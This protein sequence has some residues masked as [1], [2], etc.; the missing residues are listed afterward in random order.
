M[1][2]NKDKFRQ[3]QQSQNPNYFYYTGELRLVA[4]PRPIE[5]GQ[6]C[7]VVAKLKEPAD[8][9]EV[10]TSATDQYQIDPV[11]D[12]LWAGQI[13]VPTSTAKTLPIA[14]VIQSGEGTFYKAYT[15]DVSA[16]NPYL[17]EEQLA[18]NAFGVTPNG[19]S[20]T[21]SMNFQSVG[22]RLT[23]N[24]L[25]N[26]PFGPVTGN[27]TVKGIKTISV[28]AKFK[29][30]TKD[31]FTE[32]MTRDENL[33]ITVAGK[34]ANTDVKA[35]FQDSSVKLDDSNH[36]S[37]ELKNEHGELIF[38]EY[39]MGLAGGEFSSFSKRLNGVK[40]VGHLGEFNVYAMISEAKGSATH[41]K[42]YGQNS[43]GPYS[44]TQRPIIVNSERI[45]YKGK[46]LKRDVDYSIDYELGQI[47]FKTDFV[48]ATDLFTV[49]YEYSDAL[50]RKNF[51]A[52][53]AEYAPTTNTN[54][55]GVT[56]LGL[57]ESGDSPT[58]GIQPRSHSQVGID[59]RWELQ[60]GLSIT[61]EAAISDHAGTKGVAFKQGVLAKSDQ[62]E[63]SG[64]VKKIGESFEPVGNPSLY[65][66][67]FG[68][69]F[70]GEWTPTASF[71]VK[72]SQELNR[73]PKNGTAVQNQVWS[74]AEQ[75][76]PVSHSFLHRSDRDLSTSGN[77]FDKRL[78]RNKVGLRTE[79]GVISLEPAYQIERSTDAENPTVNATN[80]S[81]FLHANL[82]GVDRIQLAS[83]IEWQRQQLD[84]Q[85]Q[86]SRNSYALSAAVEPLANYS[87]NGTAKLVDDQ[88]DGTSALSTLGYTLKPTRQIRLNGNYD[89]ETLLMQ[90]DVAKYRVMKHQAN[91]GFG[92]QP[93][94]GVEL[95]YRYKPSFSEVKPLQNLRY[96]DRLVR[97]YGIDLDY[98]ANWTLQSELKS[99]SRKTLNTHQF[100]ASVAQ[101]SGIEDALIVQNTYRL[102]E[103]TS[104][105][106]TFESEIKSA[107]D[108]QT[109]VTPNVT[110]QTNQTSQ[111]QEAK[112]SSQLTPDIKTGL[113][114]RLEDLIFTST[115]SPSA[116][117][118]QVTQSLDTEAEWQMNP[119]LTTKLSTATSKT[120]DHL[121]RNPDT[122]FA[123]PR[124]DFRYRPTH[125]W[126][127]TGF[128][129]ITQSW[130]GQPIRR[131]R[132]SFAAKYDT[133]IQ[134]VLNTTISGQ[135]DYEN[136]TAPTQ[137]DT[138][139]ALMKMSLIF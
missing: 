42:I 112:L 98:F 40:G 48:S 83:D 21:V 23:D 59:S 37:V 46:L 56:Y 4:I 14:V 25:L 30:G 105:S 133:L 104:L 27:L 55:I 122:Y 34:A 75:Y 127:F 18:L 100:P 118:N 137:Y 10:W 135:I 136:E 79:F 68:T 111:K 17:M 86:N 44:L 134:D 72:G 78:T 69:E 126:T 73:Y 32:G 6:P 29:S 138:W 26:T 9:I 106:H 60:P 108:L 87:F 66:G 94:S 125:E 24:N 124:L 123:V 3:I 16:K 70:R 7:Y 58:P 12:T 139:D 99:T 11:S 85:G 62:A 63:F 101:S 8:R 107:N 110:D 116:N 119:Q 81:I 67:L 121:G 115:F 114:I 120:V 35:T 96:D 74:T 128:L 89:L 71:S 61:N 54:A 2:R 22:H 28:R 91:F 53:R 41:D 1:N 64:A 31:G 45:S 132:A 76:G 51:A 57:S 5:P 129:E 33:N 47:T 84:F 103:Q 97:Q 95:S 20:N 131:K 13:R 77:Y 43:Q 38:G 117:Q 88:R 39:Q 49:D 113:G 80:A 52:F 102:S 15:L 109:S 93:M 90:F 50:F 92:V 19:F 130:A 36:N 82:L 65:P